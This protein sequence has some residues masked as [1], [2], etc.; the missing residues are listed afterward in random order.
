ML[1]SLLAAALTVALAGQPQAVA[2]TSSPAEQSARATNAKI[3]QAL[4]NLL[5]QDPERVLCTRQVLTSSRQPRTTCGSVKRWFDSRRPEEKAAERAPWQL[6]AEIVR[7]RARAA[8][9][10]SGT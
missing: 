7:Q 6:V 10:R 8:G 4:W 1:S 5:E 3:E 9:R 2:A